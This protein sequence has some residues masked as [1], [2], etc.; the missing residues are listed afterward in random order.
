MEKQKFLNH[1]HYIKA[2]IYNFLTTE[3]TILVK[4]KILSADGSR[5]IYVNSNPILAIHIWKNLQLFS[6]NA[7]KCLK[8]E[9]TNI[10]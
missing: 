4:Y 10:R 8:R 2:D 9:Y 3:Q 7:Q 5:T 6:K 1:L